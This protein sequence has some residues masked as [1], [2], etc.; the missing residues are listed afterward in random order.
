MFRQVKAFSRFDV[1]SNIKR[2]FNSFTICILLLIFIRVVQEKIDSLTSA[3]SS[4][5][6]SENSS[7]RRRKMDRS[8]T[9]FL[10][11]LPSLLLSYYSE[12]AR[13][14]TTTRL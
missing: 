3:N 1:V 8:L 4:F 7:M 5:S 13:S 10:S 12:I 6:L 9:I 11:T 14:L 2:V